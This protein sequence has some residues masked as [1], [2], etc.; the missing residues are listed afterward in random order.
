MPDRDN[1]FFETGQSA[2]INPELPPDVIDARIKKIEKD[3]KVKRQAVEIPAWSEW[4]QSQEKRKVNV[5]IP[6]VQSLGGGAPAGL[7]GAPAQVQ[8]RVSPEAFSTISDTALEGGGELAGSVIGGLL[9]GAAGAA[10]TP[11]TGPLGLL[12]GAG[13]G[14]V[15]GSGVGGGLGKGASN[16]LQEMYGI[17]PEGSALM[18]AARGAAGELGGRALAAL[19]NVWRRAVRGAPASKTVKAMEDLDALNIPPRLDLVSKGKRMFGVFDPE[20][21]Y[22]WLQQNPTTSTRIKQFADEA[23]EKAAAALKEKALIPRAGKMVQPE[24][25]LIGPK[26]TRGVKKFDEDFHRRAKPMYD[27]FWDMLPSGQNTLMKVDNMH[28]FIDKELPMDEFVRVF[29]T[30]KMEKFS[31]I[32][33]DVVEIK[34]ALPSGGEATIIRELPLERVKA[35]R[36]RVGE[37]LGRVELDPDLPRD[38]LR[39]LYAALSEDM[40]GA[41]TRADELRVAQGLEPGAAKAFSEAN[42]YFSGNAGM[43]DDFIGGI[44]DKVKSSQV[45]GAV[46]SLIRNDDAKELGHLKYALGGAKSREWDAVRKY[47]LWELGFDAGGEPV[48]YKQ[49]FKKLS[50]MAPSTR[51]VLF[52]KAGSSQFRRDIDTLIRVAK[53]HGESL[54]ASN[55]VFSRWTKSGMLG[56]TAQ[57]GLLAGGG[58]ASYKTKSPTAVAGTLIGLG[59]LTLVTPRGLARLMANPQVVRKIAQNVGETTLDIGGH[60]GRLGALATTLDDPEDRRAV[61]ELLRGYQAVTDP[62]QLQSMM[63]GDSIMAWNGSGTFSRARDWTDDQA[64]GVKMLAANFDEEDDNTEAGINACLAKNG[65]NAMT[66]ALN[67]GSQ[68]LTALAAG[69]G[70]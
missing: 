30:P 33:R 69:H 47:T 25:F 45:R 58:Y 54:D 4:M 56:P 51:N 8:A 35:L 14:A 1:V 17:E 20:S 28:A 24:P 62:G 46:Q 19:P 21:V 3:F 57:V 6:I 61:I 60:I 50:D 63:L 26:V 18:G 66:G 41:A 55:S 70:S 67:M 7:L 59:A 37:V 23:I 34:K 40:R 9:G 44:Y 48:G 16:R 65:E 31:D 43:V 27:K 12:A 32:A 10:T 38:Q 53:E 22:T 49:M 68:Q 29:T 36:S 13:K 2:W 52:G 15:M 11:A 42:A 5:N 64:A 39:K